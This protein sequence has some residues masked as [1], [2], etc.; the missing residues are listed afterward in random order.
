MGQPWLAGGSFRDHLIFCAITIPPLEPKFLPC[1]I[2]PYL[3][4]PAS[5]SGPNSMLPHTPLNPA[6]L[7]HR[8]VSPNHH[9]LPCEEPGHKTWLWIGLVVMHQIPFCYWHITPLRHRFI[10]FVNGWNLF[11]H[12]CGAFTKLVPSLSQLENW[13]TVES[14][15]LL[16]NS[17][18]SYLT[19]SK[20]HNI[21]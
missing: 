14:I 5:T 15:F 2:P 1:N 13:L 12:F 16:Y 7:L 21:S 8:A 4:R 20:L 10:S 6:V 19:I 17:W 11:E 18:M 9:N 3:P